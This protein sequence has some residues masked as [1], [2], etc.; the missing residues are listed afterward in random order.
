[1]QSCLHCGH[2]ALPEARFCPACGTQLGESKPGR[3]SQLGRTLSGKYRVVRE[4]GS[5]G[6]GTVY[7]A[8]HTALKKLV[9]VKV[10]HPDLYV[11]AETIQR[12]Q[13]EGIAAG[14]FTHAGAIQ[15]FDFDKDE[16]GVFY[17]AM[18]YVEGQT[19][20]QLLR[21]ESAIGVERAIDIIAQVLRVLAEA[22]T[23]GIVHRDLKP[24]N[25]MLL[26]SGVDDQVKVLDFGLSK[27]VDLP[28]EASLM[29]QVGRIMGTPQYMSPEQCAGKEV[30]ARS[31]LYAAGLILH[32]L[33]SG[34]PTFPGDSIPEILVK[35]TSQAPPS[36]VDTH[37]ELQIPADLDSLIERALRKDPAERFDS[38]GEMLAALNAVRLDHFRKP[39]S[40]RPSR[41]PSRRALVLVALLLLVALAALASQSG[42]FSTL[43]RPHSDLLSALASEDRTAEESRYV[44]LLR[45]S[46]RA[47][48]QRDTDLALVTIEDAMR[49]PCR[50]AEAFL[51]RALIY[52]ARSDRDAALADADEA[53]RLFPRYAEV[54]AWRAW[55]SL[56]AHEL[57]AADHSFD[58]ALEMRADCAL[59]LA[60]KGTVAWLSQ[61][62]ALA[63]DFLKRAIVID[64]EQAQAHTALGMLELER[65]ELDAAVSAFVRAKRADASSWRAW[66][67]LGRAYM[68][69]QRFEEAEKQLREAIQLNPAAAESCTLLAGLLVELGRKSDARELIEEAL[70]RFGEDDE[71]QLLWALVRAE[72]ERGDAIVALEKVL[73]RARRPSASLLLGQLL[74]EEGRRQDALAAIEEA[75]A[76]EGALAQ[77]VDA[78]RDRGLLLFQLERFEEALES[79]TRATQAAPEEA[80]SYLDLG[81][82]QMQFGDDPQAAR[83]SFDRF[84]EL[85]GQDARVQEWLGRL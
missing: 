55:S 52:T 4:L 74:M 3:Q 21:T 45:D 39:R 49:L 78:W 30:D 36:L 54:E 29:T 17:L 58:R 46:R 62:P 77:P 38:A 64:P 20:G 79:F 28:L 1:M 37:P 6:M 11:S 2:E 51:L 9:A 14:K 67:G 69:Q 80:A 82:L 8:E 13:R 41:L 83:A 26:S 50:D 33:L 18:E 61:Q 43:S 56:E 35:Q 15:I 60:G 7:L 25:I 32:E 63:E 81:I 16:S 44:Q 47:L 48:R 53:L 19:L 75:L 72:D 24:D 34:Q 66:E 57:E 10:L 65:D 59:A 68:R 71:L 12:F 84:R 76:D 40:E 73:E 85:G 70:Q 42:L 5:G 27:L 22:H 31:D 23:H